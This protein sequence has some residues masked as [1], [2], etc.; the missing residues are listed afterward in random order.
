MGAGDVTATNGGNYQDDAQAHA[1][2]EEAWRVYWTQR[3]MRPVSHFGP[4]DDGFGWCRRN[5]DLV[6]LKDRWQG[7]P[8]EVH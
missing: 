1:Y 7:I 8:G 2:L 4:V 5:R 6:I 3:A